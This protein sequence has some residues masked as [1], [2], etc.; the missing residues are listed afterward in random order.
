MDAMHFNSYIDGGDGKMIVQM[1]ARSGQP[2]QVRGCI[3]KLTG[4]DGD[5]DSEEGK[6]ALKEHMQKR[7]SIDE[8]KGNILIMDGGKKKVLCEDTF[9]TAGVGQK[10]TSGFGS[11]MRECLKGKIDEKRASKKVSEQNQYES[12][13]GTI[14]RMVR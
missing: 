2:S 12:L 8:E 5:T 14:S 6:K 4:Y 1:G 3:A 7:C 11:A 10:V 9:R 13:E